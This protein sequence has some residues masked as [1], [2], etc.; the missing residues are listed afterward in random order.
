MELTVYRQASRTREDGRTVYLGEDAR[1]YVD[2]RAFWVA[3]GLGGAAAMRHQKMKRELFDSEKLL[4]TL[5]KGVY[6]DYGDERFVRY[7]TD[8]FF[9]LFAVK[10]IYA[11]NLYNMKKSGYFASRLVTAILLHTMLYDERFQ[12][13][14]LFGGL[15]AAREEG[16]DAD[17]LRELGN[18]F[19]KKMQSDLRLIAKNANL[20][21]ESAFSGLALLGSTLCVAIYLENEDSVEA[22]YLTAGDSRPYVWTEEEGLCQI[23]EDQKRPDGGMTNYI[24]ANEDADFEIRCDFMRFEKPCILFNASDGCYDSARFVSQ[25]AFEKLILDTI[26]KADSP[27]DAGRRLTETFLE[28]ERGGDDSSTIAMKM[29][30]FE[31]YGALRACASR[32]LEKMD[33]EY[34]SVMPGLLDM[35][36]TY[37]YKQS[38][39]AFP[40]KF[41]EI[42]EKL[43]SEREVLEYCKKQV[44][45]G[46]YP[47]YTLQTREMDEKIAA[48]RRIINDSERWITDILARNFFRFAPC[49]DRSD[50]P[51]KRSDWSKAE[52]TDMAYRGRA[53]DYLSMLRQY[54]AAFAEAVEN[55]GGLLER[56]Y[57]IGVPEGFADYDEISLQIVEECERSMDGLFEFFHALKS[58]KSGIVKKLTRLRIEY[59]D[60]S[61]KE[62]AKY[63]ERLR[64]LREMIASGELDPYQVEL[65]ADDRSELTTEMERIRRAN[66]AIRSL[67]EE[68][69]KILAG[70]VEKYW[71]DSHADIIERMISDH[72]PEIS[73]ELIAQAKTVALE[74]RH[75]IEELKERS[76]LQQKLFEKYGEKYCRYRKGAGE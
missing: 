67:E 50:P 57:S 33:E 55:L 56:V 5:F 38:T 45:G 68:K 25:M 24:R 30:G 53:D 27:E 61:R 73:D 23:L 71:N 13:E 21:Y 41:S 29:F 54:K 66:E 1:P 39:A 72:P 65:F 36:Y 4:D 26:A 11:D 35:D 42:R 15:K 75:Q 70:C 43:Q 52:R 62:A 3:D 37:A 47:P 48:I 16:K 10:D 19:A 18:Y 51:D 9:E 69:E 44:E 76:E 7:V 34:L 28:Y 49:P 58:K 64:A 59:H 2:E 31:D 32:R 74:T 60:R 22:I 63:P 46:G 40:K 14:N 17:Y 6:A 20:I 8:S 12:T